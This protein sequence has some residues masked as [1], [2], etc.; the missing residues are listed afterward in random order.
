PGAGLPE[1]SYP[2]A[3]DGDNAQRTIHR[4]PS[5]LL[6]A[7]APKGATSPPSNW[8]AAYRSVMVAT[9]RASSVRTEDLQADEESRAEA[10]EDHGHEHERPEPEC[11]RSHGSLTVTGA[12]PGPV[13]KPATPGWLPRAR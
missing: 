1:W 12:T 9:S 11:G 7:D 6:G 8:P 5:R 4:N 2:H 3:A 13:L 10:D